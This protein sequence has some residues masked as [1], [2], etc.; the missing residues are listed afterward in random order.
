MTGMLVPGDDGRNGVF[1]RLATLALLGIFSAGPARADAVNDLYRGETIITG[2]ENL[3]ERARGIRLA[4][5]QVLVKVSGDD[6]I[7]DNPAFQ[8]ILADAESYVRHFEYEDRKKGI[9]I[10]DEQGTRDRSY[11][12]RVDFDPH[13]IDI[14]LQVLGR[15][16]WQAD[17][18]RMLVVLAV[19]DL[20]GSYVV[21]SE[22]QRG[23]GQRETLVSNA[24]RRGLPL[25]MPKMDTVETLAL[26]H[27]AV[28]EADGGAIGALATSYGADAVLIGA[29]EITDQGYW[30]TDWTLMTDEMPVRWRVP[31]ATFDRS[32]SQ[33]LGESARTLAGIR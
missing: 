22:G 16:S 26:S 12:F 1:I 17:R 13:G 29:M 33:A 28:V 27:D 7:V 19:T 23:Q 4:L 20:A 18:P 11:Y 25:V 15:S 5:G 31:N 8:P 3:H 2:Q 9:Q 32:I 10:S 6:R 30:N 24:G 21:G 14:I